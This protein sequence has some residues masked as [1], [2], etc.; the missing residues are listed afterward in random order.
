MA[1]FWQARIGLGHRILEVDGTLHGIY[2]T[3]KFHQRPVT[4]YL[5]NATLMMGDQGLQ[6]I[7]SSSLEGS[8]GAGLVLSHKP[9]K[10]NHVRGQYRC[11]AAFNPSFGHERRLLQGT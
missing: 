4:H 1:T 3:S 5:E 7:L 2:S 8:Q 6:N 10:T 11:K 9:T